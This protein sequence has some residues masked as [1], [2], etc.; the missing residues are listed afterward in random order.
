M[1]K[2]ISKCLSAFFCVGFLFCI[3]STPAYAAEMY[4]GYPIKWANS[5]GRTITVTYR[6]HETSNF[7][8]SRLISNLG[9][10]IRY[11]NTAG[12]I[13][14]TYDSTASFPARGMVAF[15][16]P[17]ETF[18][19]N[20]F[21]ATNAP[22]TP[23]YTQAFDT[24]G[25]LLSSSSVVSSTRQVNHSI[26]YFNPFDYY[27][28]G[29]EEELYMDAKTDNFMRHVIAHE[30]GHALGFGHTSQNTDSIMTPEIQV[31]YPQLSSSDISNFRAKYA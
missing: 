31:A 19:R 22:T 30:F 18:W 29:T 20:P 4:P 3:C 27:W 25:T 26:I 11:W 16:I 6:I 5:S 12:T 1:K 15:K 13:S 8:P 14:L 28:T 10:S 21:G 23:G 24:N 2:W 9:P 7:L 17:S